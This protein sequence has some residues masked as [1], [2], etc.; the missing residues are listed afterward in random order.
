MSQ[1]TKKA[2]MNSFLKLL[3]E[4]PLDKIT[5]KDI[6]EDCGVSRNSFYYYYQDIFALMDEIFTLETEKARNVS[7]IPDSWQD[8]L[9]E[10]L[11]FALQNKRMLINVC[12]SSSRDRVERYLY[13]VTEKVLNACVDYLARDL[14]TLEWDRRF[15]AHFYTHALVGLFLEW[16]DSGLKDE[17]E[18]SIRRM[19]TLLEGNIRTALVK[20]S[21][22]S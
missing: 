6:V 17:P 14:V 9:I 19:G 22:L 16:V 18:P 7:N 21:K 5:V 10:S 20:S 8:A 11:Q 12:R 3:N 4:K 13:S 2:I 1:F 15:I